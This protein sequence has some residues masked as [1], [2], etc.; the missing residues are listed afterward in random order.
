MAETFRAVTVLLAVTSESGNFWF[1]ALRMYS[2]HAK[3]LKVQVLPDSS[4][5]LS[6]TRVQA[7]GKPHCHSQCLVHI[8]FASVLEKRVFA[9]Q[10]IDL[11]TTFLVVCVDSHFCTQGASP[12]ERVT[13]MCVT[14]ATPEVNVL[15]WV[16]NRVRVV[17]VSLLSSRVIHPKRNGGTGG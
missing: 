3:N 6:I 11:I 12:S 13:V 7:G 1:C 17:P 2:Y 10:F 4:Q 15:H 16:I 14:P 5:S 9:F 8:E